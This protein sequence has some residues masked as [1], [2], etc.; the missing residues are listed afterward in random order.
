[1]LTIIIQGHLNWEA[2]PEE[3]YIKS[4]EKETRPTAETGMV[5]FL[6]FNLMVKNELSV[7]IHKEK[8]KRGNM[9]E[10]GM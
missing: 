8:Q 2:S 4:T 9:S 7:K 5:L 1:M 3:L 10:N 6:F